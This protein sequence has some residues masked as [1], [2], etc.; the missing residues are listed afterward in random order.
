[1]KI[2]LFSRSKIDVDLWDDF[3][4]LS[5]QNSIFLERWFMDIVEPNWQAIFIYKNGV[6]VAVMPIKIKSKLLIKYA[7]QPLFSKY[8]GIAFSPTSMVKNTE[9]IESSLSKYLKKSLRSFTYYFHPNVNL[10]S[11]F[12]KNGFSIKKREFQQLIFEGTQTAFQ[13]TNSGLKNKINKAIKSG[14]YYEESKNADHLIALISIQLEQNRFINKKQLRTFRNLVETTIHKNRGSL[15]LVYNGN[16]VLS[17]AALLMYD[18]KYAYLLHSV[19]LEDSK[20]NG[21]MPFL[22]ATCINK[23]FSLGLSF[24]FMGSIIP[25]VKSFNETF[26]AENVKYFEVRR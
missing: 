19:I 20:S 15:I 13:P 8:W 26:G 9:E 25:G 7:L 5:P 10:L 4:A 18:T 3:I 16:K 12:E 2:E 1:M 14:F 21:S 24:H 11:G 17:G 22:I 23:S 6:L